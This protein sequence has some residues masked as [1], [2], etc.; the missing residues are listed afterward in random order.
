M[1]S[2]LHTRS[3]FAGSAPS[4]QRPSAGV[5]M[6]VYNG[7]RYLQ[8]QLDSIV[9]QSELPHRI[10]IVD[11][12]STDGSW[13]LLQ[14]WARNAPF[15]VVLRRNDTNLGVSRNFEKAVGLLDQDIVFLADQ[16]DI[17]YP[18][19][20]TSFVDRFACDRELGLL[21]SDANL[22]DATGQLLGRRLLDTLLVTRDERNEVAAGRAYRVYAKRNLVTGAACAFRREL[23]AH[24]L[25]FSPEWIHDEWLAFTAALV[26]KV[27]L[28]DEATMAYRLHGSNTVGM[29]L[30][31][32]GWRL[33]TITDAFLRP[34]APR[35][36]LR[37][38]RLHEIYTHA[39]VLGAA[40]D[41]LQHLNAAAGHAEFRS[42]LPRNPFTRLARVLRERRKGHYHA[43][44]NG[45]ISMLHDL[46]VAN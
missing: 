31:T 44:S 33:R 25:P 35:Q 28:L 23:L 22:I 5:A 11:D 40:P 3:G 21:H 24:A 8:L 41:V 36:L 14:Q 38:R 16:D 2:V 17:W 46:F 39:S 34:T 43:W 42:A 9:A 37:A 32:V 26:S 1:R 30:P 13:E 15:E 29:P 20:L 12:A 4:G 19:K 27:A 7:T 18:G 6:C 45:E 10:A